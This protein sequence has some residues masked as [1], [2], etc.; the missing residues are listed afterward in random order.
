[1]STSKVTHCTLLTVTKQG[2]EVFFIDVDP[3]VVEDV[4]K[5]AL[6][7]KLRSDVTFHDV[8]GAVKAVSIMPTPSELPRASATDSGTDDDALLD[9]IRSKIGPQ[10]GSVFIDARAPSMG[11]RGHVVASK[12]DCEYSVMF[13]CWVGCCCC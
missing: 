4:V 3:V 1:M 6:Q 2:E 9:Q 13:V 5:H 12:I 10:L 8:S 7:Y 11:V